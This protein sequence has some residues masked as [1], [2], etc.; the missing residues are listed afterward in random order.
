[1]AATALHSHRL[2]CYGL[3]TSFSLYPRKPIFSLFLA[4]PTFSVVSTVS[5]YASSNSNG[6]SGISSALDLTASRSL[7]LSRASAGELPN[8]LIEDPKFVPLNADDPRYGPPALL[9]LGFELEESSKIYQL[10]EELSGDFL[11]VI[12]FTE[13]MINC[14]LLD[15]MSTQQP[16]L[17]NMKYADCKKPSSNLLFLWFKWGGDDDVH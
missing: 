3:N 16:N 15:A 5:S 4:N 9:L 14:S 6:F 13:D 1:M 7:H 11:K 17:E 12:Y 8:E 2:A 10:L